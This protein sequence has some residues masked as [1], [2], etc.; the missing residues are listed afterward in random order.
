GVT[1]VRPYGVSKGYSTATGMMRN[2][3]SAKS[4]AAMAQAVRIVS[5]SGPVRSTNRRVSPGFT[6]PISAELMTGGKVST[7]PFPSESS[8]N[9]S[10]DETMGPYSLPLG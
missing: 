10:Y 3:M 1:M 8:G 2:P 9:L 5:R 4:H 7:S 6:P